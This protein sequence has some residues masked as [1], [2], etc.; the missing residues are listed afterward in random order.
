M[1]WLRQRAPYLVL[2]AVM[3]VALHQHSADITRIRADERQ[4]NAVY[5]SG[6]RGSCLARNR[7]RDGIIG[8]VQSG[9]DRSQKAADA[10]VASPL[11]SQMQ[12][13]TAAANLAQLKRTLVELQ[14]HLPLEGC[15][16]RPS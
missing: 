3:A 8:F 9:V 7:L 12:R 15:P 14:E 11:T 6:T 13:D 10:L 2:V 1:S 4:L 16:A 5:D